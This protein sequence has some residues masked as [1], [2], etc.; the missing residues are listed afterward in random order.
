MDRQVYAEQSLTLARHPSE[1]DERMLVRLLVFAL[2]MPSDSAASVLEFG[3]DM[4]E[5]EEPCIWQKD[6][7]GRIEHWIDVGQ[8]D[9]KRM[10]RASSRADRVSVYS[11]ASS[12]PIWW[13]SVAEKVS[14]ARNLSVWQI[15]AQES[16]A[17]AG[18]A[19]RN[20]RLNVS[21]Q[22]GGVWIGNDGQSVEV[23]LRR[24]YGDVG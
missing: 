6:L 14:R 5:H 4:W 24:L 7:T 8:P 18:L 11:F 19:E 1:T 20:M 22:D 23:T 3:R 9:E 2:N 21:V 15:P 16:Q 12:T 13:G 10:L 17:L